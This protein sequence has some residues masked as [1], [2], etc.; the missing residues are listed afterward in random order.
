MALLTRALIVE[1]PSASLLRVVIPAVIDYLLMLMHS[2]RNRVPILTNLSSQPIM[3]LICAQ[4]KSWLSLYIEFVYQV[5]ASPLESALSR[6]LTRLA[7]R[8][9]SPS[10]HSHLVPALYCKVSAV[11]VISQRFCAL[12]RGLAAVEALT[13]S[14]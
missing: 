2:N 10:A 3:P 8:G 1:G 4:P 6:P 11:A 5:V 13:H 7:G 12:T 9:L 14:V